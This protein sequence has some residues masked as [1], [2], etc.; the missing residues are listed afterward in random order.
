MCHQRALSLPIAAQL[1]TIAIPATNSISTQTITEPVLTTTTPTQNT[2]AHTTTAPIAEYVMHPGGSMITTT[3]FTIQPI[4]QRTRSLPLTEETA[5]QVTSF[6]SNVSSPLPYSC[7]INPKSHNNNNNNTITNNNNC[8]P[9]Q[10]QTLNKTCSLLLSSNSNVNKTQL[11]HHHHQHH[12]ATTTTISH[13]YNRH[14]SNSLD[15]TNDQYLRGN[16]GKCFSGTEQIVPQPANSMESIVEDQTLQMADYLHMDEDPKLTAV[17]QQ[18]HANQNNSMSSSSSSSGCNNKQAASFAIGNVHSPYF[19]GG[20]PL[21][22]RRGGR[23]NAGNSSRST[24]NCIVY[25]YF[26]YLL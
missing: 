20:S 4:H 1:Q 26:L 12:P 5:I 18:Q 19:L 3:S 13:F 17:V 15:L 14:N 25:I 6:H 23:G 16:G 21:S 24:Y 9:N 11:Q 22:M 10:Q 8:Q 2:S 7:K